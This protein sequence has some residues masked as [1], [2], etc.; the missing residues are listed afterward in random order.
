[1]GLKKDPITNEELC[2]CCGLDGLHCFCPCHTGECN[3]QWK[4]GEKQCKP[5][6]HEFFLHNPGEGPGGG[7]R[8]CDW[9][10]T[11]HPELVHDAMAAG[12]DFIEA[13]ALGFVED[14]P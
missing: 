10:I 13:F 14:E 8:K 2:T 7:C 6:E 11:F 1:M 3:S 9:T 12:V 5:D 4:K